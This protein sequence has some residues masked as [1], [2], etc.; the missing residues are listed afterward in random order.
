M[1]EVVKIS[2][3]IKTYIVEGC[4]GELKYESLKQCEG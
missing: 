3:L 4:E 1:V 2:H